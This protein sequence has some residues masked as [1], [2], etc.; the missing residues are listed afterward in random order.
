M[1]TVLILMIITLLQLCV[2]EKPKIKK[3]SHY[4]ILFEVQIT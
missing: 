4:G 3:L 1:D 2:L